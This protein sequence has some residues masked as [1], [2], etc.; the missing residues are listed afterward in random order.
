VFLTSLDC[1]FMLDEEKLI[2]ECDTTNIQK[3]L[4]YQIQLKYFRLFYKIEIHGIR[5]KQN[6]KQ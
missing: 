5:I 3:P 1:T 4:I 2:L 6:T